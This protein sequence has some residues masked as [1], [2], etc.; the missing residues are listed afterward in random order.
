MYII[1]YTEPHNIVL[2]WHLV[3]FYAFTVHAYFILS[4]YVPRIIE[5]LTLQ[6]ILYKKHKSSE[7]IYRCLTRL[8]TVERNHPPFRST[9]NN[10]CFFLFVLLNYYFVFKY[11]Y[12]VIKLIYSY[13]ILF[14]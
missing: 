6:A 5:V 2:L 7:I 14:Y 11:T 12:I 10:I 9:Y 8:I 13:T 4:I 3:V 1:L